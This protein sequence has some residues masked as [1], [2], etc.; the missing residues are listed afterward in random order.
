MED[1]SPE[2]LAVW[3][4][5]GPSEGTFR[6]DETSYRTDTGGENTLSV[7]CLTTA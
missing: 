7:L 5:L 3:L 4:L 1:G 6:S 2:L